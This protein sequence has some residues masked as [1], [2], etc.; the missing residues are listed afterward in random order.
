[1]ISE[2][3]NEE[4]ILATMKNMGTENNYLVEALVDIAER[5]DERENILA[6]DEPPIKGKSKNTFLADLRA[7]PSDEI[8]ESLIDFINTDRQNNR[9]ISA[10]RRVLNERLRK[11]DKLPSN[12]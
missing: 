10:A 3:N 12:N 9:W 5:K 6:G 2:N 4:T 11:L 1:M 7:M 8:L